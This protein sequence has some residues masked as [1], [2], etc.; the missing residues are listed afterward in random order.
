MYDL[1]DRQSV[2]DIAMSYCPDDDGCC[3]KAFNDIREL[4]DDIENLPAVNHCIPCSDNYCEFC[5]GV[6]FSDEP[7]TVIT[8][9]DKQVDCVFKFCPNCGRKLSEGE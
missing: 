6:S 2:V 3:S 9:K 4:L 7:F 5:D 1:I 8:H